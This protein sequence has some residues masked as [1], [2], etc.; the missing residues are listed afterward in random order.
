M[1]TISAW[2]SPPTPGIRQTMGMPEVSGS[3]SPAHGASTERSPDLPINGL[4]DREAHVA[5][6]LQQYRHWYDRKAVRSKALYLRMRT[7]S[8]VGGAIV[9]VLVNSMSLISR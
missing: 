9:P 6:R 4:G 5:D 8:V 7:G 3:E 2:Y 1:V